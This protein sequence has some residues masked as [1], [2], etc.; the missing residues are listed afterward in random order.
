MIPSVQRQADIVF[1]EGLG[2]GAGAGDVVEVGELAAVVERIVTGETV[3]ELGHPPGETLNF[4]DAAEAGC[5]ILREKVGTGVCI[6]SAEGFGEDADVGYGEVES[7]GAGGRDDVCGVA[8]EEKAAEL[9][10][11]DDEA[12]H[13]GDGFLDDGTFGEF[14][15]VM[16]GEALVEFAPDAMIGPERKVFIGRALEIEAA[17]FGRAHGKQRKA[18]M[19]MDVNEFLG[20]RRRLRE[21]AEPAE[22]IV[23]FVNGEDARG[24]GGAADSVEAVAT[25]DEVAIEALG[26][27]I[28][29][30][31]DVGI[32][33]VERVERDFGCFE[34]DGAI[35]GQAGR[36]EVLN[37][38]VL[39]VDG[40]ALAVGEI[41]EV[42]SMAA[43]VEAKFDA[44]VFE[45]LEAETFA[46]TEF[47]HELDGVVF[48]KAGADA[49]FN[50][51][52]GV[53]F[54]D[55]GFYAEAVEE[56]REEEAGGSGADD[57]DL[58]AHGGQ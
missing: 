38:F 7:F 23:A 24:D 51:R 16:R 45:A 12:A 58:C 48:E 55:D 52:A 31:R 11:L 35:G 41:A 21:D 56:E 2:G 43:P 10:G 54:E 25:G 26:G 3:E 5:G 49:L 36:N 18:T 42:N 20:C 34:Q 40:D 27:A 47:V 32:R 39:G 13:A 14:P 30:E 8:G 15:A 46:D 4:P 22:G 17:D 57:G 6:E 53:E 29:L 1:G 37:D 9:H 28:V 33:G 44:A 50:V 19:V